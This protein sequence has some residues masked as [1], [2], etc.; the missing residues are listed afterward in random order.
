MGMDGQFHAPVTLSAVKRLRA[1]CTEGWVG[2]R[3][4][5]DLCRKSHPY[6]V[7]CGEQMSGTNFRMKENRDGRH[8][9]M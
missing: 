1:H 5:M 9:G 2:P 8:W 3:A 7:K 6:Q 4:G